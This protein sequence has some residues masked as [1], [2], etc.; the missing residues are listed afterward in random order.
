MPH[1]TLSCIVNV[2]IKINW[3]TEGLVIWQVSSKII[4]TTH[5]LL[6][7][8]DHQLLHLLLDF[9]V[10]GT[11]LSGRLWSWWCINPCLFQARLHYCSLWSSDLVCW[12]SKES[13]MKW[14]KEITPSSVFWGDS[15]EM[16]G[17]GIL[18][19]LICVFLKCL[20]NE[21]CFWIRKANYISLSQKVLKQS[22]LQKY[23]AT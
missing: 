5:I 11:E 7:H 19:L 3:A 15:W 13:V 10:L 2:T 9:R 18:C 8:S 4:K 17:R 23:K 20:R 6:S 16:E 22:H 14:L 1:S 21:R 12:M